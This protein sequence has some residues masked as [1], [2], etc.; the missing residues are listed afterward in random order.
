LSDTD[1]VQSVLS[2]P[3]PHIDALA[4]GDWNLEHITKHSVTPDEVEE[5]LASDAIYRSSYKNRIVVTGPTQAGRM[6]T[7][8]IGESPRRARPATNREQREYQREK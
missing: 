4:W 8:I 1:V 5:V 2:E 3:H 7:V 6:L